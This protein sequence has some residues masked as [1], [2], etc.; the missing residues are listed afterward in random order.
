MFY[1]TAPGLVMWVLDWGMRFYELRKKLD[2]KV[3]HLGNGW[4]SLVLGLPRHRLDG[5]ACTSPLAHFYIH[6]AESSV[7]ELHPFTTITH[8]A[9]Q[10]RLTPQ[11]EDDLPVQFLFR[12][13]GVAGIPGTTPKKH[14]WISVFNFFSVK[15]TPS[16]QWTDKLASLADRAPSISDDVENLALDRSSSTLPS[17]ESQS[18]PLNRSQPLSMVDIGLRLEGPY[19]TPADPSRYNTVICFVAG[20][21][22]SG[23]IAIGAAFID[24]KRQQAS[25]QKEE[26]DTLPNTKEA[27]SLPAL[28]SSSKYSTSSTW[29]RCIIFWSVRAADYVELP[30]FHDPSSSLD[31]HVHRTGADRPRLDI[32]AALAAVCDESPGAST[33]CYLSGPN[34]FIAAGEKACKARAG[35]D[36]YGARWDI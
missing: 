11:T 32:A 19:F 26:E 15:P 22:V 13:R 4:Y 1:C 18:G 28:C 6:H 35:V 34:A 25:R 21:G 31:L 36:F 3:I 24:M 23:A 2:G 30:F 10:N 9:S 7:R 29:Q 5:C 33:W 8:L 14:A 12:K 16:F 27:L 17:S 20:T